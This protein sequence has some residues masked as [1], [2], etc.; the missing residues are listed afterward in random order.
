MR[1][2]A[3]L[4]STWLMT[5]VSLVAWGAAWHVA[6]PPL[7]SDSNPGTDALPFGTIQ[8]GID[9]AS[10]G[11]TVTVAEGTYR[12]NIQFK[13]TNLVLTSTNPLDPDVVAGTIIDA[14]QA[15]SVVT[16]SGTETEACVLSGFTIRNGSTSGNGGG[17]CGGTSAQRSQA[18]IEN[19]TITGN[20]AGGPWV[21]GGGGGLAF[22]NGTI[23]NN[24]I[25]GNSAYVTG[26]GLACCD[27]T[28][29][30][31]T[32]SDNSADYGEGGGLYDCGGRIENN[33]ITGNWSGGAYGGAGGG[34]AFCNG[35]VHNNTIADN[36]A[37]VSG[38][39]LAYC[40]GTI[41]NCIIWGNTAPTSPQLRELSI[42]TYCC[43]QEWSGG[44]EGNI[45]EDPLFLDP[46]GPDNDPA[47][48]E[49]NDY[50]L[51]AGSPCIDAGLNDAWMWTATDL[52]GN[53]RVWGGTVDMGAY[54]YGSRLFRISQVLVQ[55][56]GGLQLTWTSAPGVAYLIWSC[57][58]LTSGLWTQEAAVPS[59]GDS[60]SWTDAGPSGSQEFYRVEEVGL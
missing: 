44:G 58:D 6:P 3:I 47:T 26:G 40:E 51:S 31:N 57:T 56:G 33:T 54:E 37:Y 43:I 45:S 39:G 15:G 42:P 22:C 53:P 52:D 60:T 17:I 25:A 4:L 35:T 38:G 30:N 8:H 32:I 46:D 5:L 27:G 9:A 49:D 24:V 48:Q 1:S 11:D 20:S 2:I 34:L 55:I 41:Q 29:Q 36:A 14:S 12:E 50:R 7:G 10:S 18:S 21:G 13:G 59:A 16:F 23:Q 28:V 19:N